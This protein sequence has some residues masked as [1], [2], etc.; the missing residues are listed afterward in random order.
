MLS[1]IYIGIFLIIFSPLFTL[2]AKRERK[3]LFPISITSIFLSLSVL[4]FIAYILDDGFA[5]SMSWLFFV[6]FLTI[7]AVFDLPVI[8]RHRSKTGFVIIT[9]FAISLFAFHFID[10]S[11]VKPFKRFYNSIQIGMTKKEVAVALHQE[12]PDGGRFPVPVP[13]ENTNHFGFMLDPNKG[14]YN[15]EDVFVMLQDG[16]V[17]SKTYSPD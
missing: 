17:A 12:F 14:E 10:F 9:L 5:L 3:W 13:F 7:A 1:S 15:A 11:P 16:R 8:L 4:L 6:V 2:L